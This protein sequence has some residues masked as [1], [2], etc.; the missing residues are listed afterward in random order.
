MSIW[1]VY[2]DIDTELG[3]LYFRN[4]KRAYEYMKKTLEDYVSSY[5]EWGDREKVLFYENELEELE[6]EYRVITLD[7]LSFGAN[8]VWARKEEV[9]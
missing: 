8:V 7:D 2:F 9:Y 5:N 3:N 6:R 1:V 4:A